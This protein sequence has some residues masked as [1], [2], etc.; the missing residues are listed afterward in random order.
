MPRESAAR[1]RAALLRRFLRNWQGVLG[2]A[3]VV[4]FVA[5]ALLAPWIAPHSPT[6]TDL[7]QTLAA[8]SA[9][10]LVA[11]DFRPAARCL[12]MRATR[13]PSSVRSAR[14]ALTSA[15]RAS[16]SNSPFWFVAMVTVLHVA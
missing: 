8:P 13:D 7:M 16:A 1:E 5:S 6:H 9:I 15:L 2:L 14:S 10:V 3:L 12:P 4:L 11:A